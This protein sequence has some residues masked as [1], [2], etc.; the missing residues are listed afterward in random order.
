[1]LK[2][3]RTSPLPY[4]AAATVV[5]CGLAVYTDYAFIGDL[6]AAA[7]Q[8]GGSSGYVPNR[9][10]DGFAYQ[11]LGIQQILTAGDWHVLFQQPNLL[12]HVVRY[13]L[14][15]PFVFAGNLLGPVAPILML[16]LLAAPLVQAFSAPASAFERLAWLARPVVP[17]LFVV[18]SGRSILVAIGL[19]YTMMALVPSRP[20]ARPLA[21]GVLL[22]VF[23]S[24][25][26]VITVLVVGV[27]YV[28]KRRSRIQ[29]VAVLVLVAFMLPSVANKFIGFSEGAAGFQSFDDATVSSTD[30]S[31][32]PA[33]KPCDDGP[34]CMV[35]R[36]ATRST[37]YTSWV[38]KQDTR[39]V[40]Y[41]GLLVASLAALA[42]DVFRRPQPLH[43]MTVAIAAGLLGLAVEGLGAWTL[44]FPLLWRYSWRSG[45]GSAR[46][47]AL[48][49]V[50]P[51]AQ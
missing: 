35:L 17:L 34:H 15:L 25:S 7:K 38:Y 51:E 29:V 3:A 14:C 27:D 21:V 4:Y 26:I 32:R 39:L 16:S 42:L 48:G 20:R 40:L 6:Q 11:Y 36:V 10:A 47:D 37:L 1:M 49:Q 33:F 46:D 31:L 30:G 43:P 28:I 8:S 13:V 24:I 18:L 5:A 12:L 9:G 41:V 44:L 19:G 50:A 22:S 45:I 2:L 23:S